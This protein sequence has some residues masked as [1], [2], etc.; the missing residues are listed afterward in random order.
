[1]DVIILTK[2]GSATHPYK[3]GRISRITPNR[4]CPIFSN[5]KATPKN[6]IPSKTGIHKLL[7]LLDSR[8]HGSEKL[9]II[10]GSQK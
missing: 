9:G 2:N 3:G 1:M 6:V 7:T 5:I 8:L 4:C 10:R